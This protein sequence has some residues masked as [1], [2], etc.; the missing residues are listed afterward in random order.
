MQG[1]ERGRI[2]MDVWMKECKCGDGLRIVLRE[3]RL[4]RACGF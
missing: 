2:G 1:R 4:N 3:R